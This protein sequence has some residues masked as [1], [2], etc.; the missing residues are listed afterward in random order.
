VPW[1]RRRRLRQ[2]LDEIQQQH[3]PLLLYPAPQATP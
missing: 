1:P 2:A 3:Q